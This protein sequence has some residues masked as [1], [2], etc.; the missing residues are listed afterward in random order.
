MPQRGLPAINF[1]FSFMINR[2]QQESTLS[3]L[4]F[5][6]KTKTKTIYYTHIYLWHHPEF[7]EVNLS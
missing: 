6:G 7:M 2:L 5:N 3:S 1:F 4:C